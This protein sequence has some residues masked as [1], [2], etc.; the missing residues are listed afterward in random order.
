MPAKVMEACGIP[1]DTLY[2]VRK[3]I[4]GLPDS[5]RA[6]YL[7]YAELL[8]SAGY[9]KSRCDPCLFMKVDKSTGERVYIWTHVDDTF[10]AATSTRLR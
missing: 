5:G 10:V 9:M 3:Y 6:Y 1:S 4:Y 2:R 8:M 7:A